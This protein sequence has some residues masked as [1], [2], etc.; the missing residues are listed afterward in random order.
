MAEV[1]TCLGSS[2]RN[3]LLEPCWTHQDRVGHEWEAHAASSSLAARQSAEFG[4]RQI[5]PTRR[6]GWPRL[7]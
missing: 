4:L 7:R 3:A 1:V 5:T 2:D 6:R